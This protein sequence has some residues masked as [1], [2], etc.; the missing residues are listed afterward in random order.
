MTVHTAPVDLI[1]AEVLSTRLDAIGQ[2]AGAAVEQTAI[3]PVVTE[4]KDYSVTIFNARGD[5]LTGSSLAPGHFGA[6]MNAVRT[7]LERYGDK[8]ADGDVYFSNDPHNGGGMHPQDIVIQKPV[9]VNGELVAWVALAAHMMDMGGMVPGSSASLA[10]ECFQEA[11]RMPP[12]R[13]AR[14]GKELTD[15][16]DIILNNIRSA[17]SIEMDIRS[18]VIGAHVAADKLA[19]LIAEV[20]PGVFA[21]TAQLLIDST[22]RVLRERIALI[23]DGVYRTWGG[24]E[25]RD[26]LLVV[27]VEL[28][29]S[30]DR[31]HFDV[32]KAPPQVPLFINSK[33]YIIRAIVAPALRMMLGK[34]LPLNQACYNVVEL[35]TTPGTIVDSIVPAPIAAAHMDTGR[36]VSG[37]VLQALQLA[38]NASPTAWEHEVSTAPQTP[39]YATSRWSYGGANGAREAFTLIDGALPGGPAAAGRDGVDLKSGARAASST[40]LEFADIEI[41]ETAYPILFSE[42]RSR[43]N[44]AGHGQ[45]RAG[46]GLEEQFEPHGAD[47]L[48]ANLTGTKSWLPPTGAAGGLPGS[49]TQY[50]LRRGDGPFEVAHVHAVGLKLAPGDMFEIACCSG[51]GFG[52]PLDRDLAAVARDVE[53]DRVDEMTARDIYGAEFDQQGRLDEA[54]S[55]LRREALRADR[56]RRAK[57]PSASLQQ[58]APASEESAPLYPGIVQR[59]RYAVA[60]LSGAVLAVA[61]GNWLEGCATIDTPHTTKGGGLVLRQYLD[62]LS[63]RLLYADVIGPDQTA[64]VEILPERW[65]QAA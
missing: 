54:A 11:L 33:P 22:E 9:V 25:F 35:E 15:V 28:R 12:V 62:P 34:T 61:P 58:A 53:E 10:T 64:S 18:L 31:L 7:T 40:A 55:R 43:R 26:E 1:L 23:E 21:P 60:E 46:A 39:G 59:G 8:I 32:T 44:S 3:S 47:D 6:A 5:I 41:L 50:R 19:K 4:S 63:G 24:V 45:F 27:P 14:G 37:A 56:L 42:R 57:R 65:T 20:G 16:W 52:E 17:K 48:I 2:E 51:G 13:L 49:L 38:I 36:A 29:V 30:G